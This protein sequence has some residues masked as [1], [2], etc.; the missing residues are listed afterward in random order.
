MKQFT[1]S[2]SRQGDFHSDLGTSWIQEL[3]LSALERNICLDLLG[4]SVLLSSQQGRHLPGLLLW[5]DVGEELWKKT[6]PVNNHFLRH[7]GRIMSNFRTWKGIYSFFTGPG[8][9]NELRP[10]V[11]G[12]SSDCKISHWENT[13]SINNLREAVK[14]HRV[15]FCQERSEILREDNFT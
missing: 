4:C 11:P 14:S 3:F 15:V 12:S 2:G 10:C 1:S 8:K 6:Q 7:P 5:R 9:E 13:G